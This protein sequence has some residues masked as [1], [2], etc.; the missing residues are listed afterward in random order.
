MNV[1]PREAVIPVHP[2][3]DRKTYSEKPTQKSQLQ[4]HEPSKPHLLA[5]MS[6]WVK[7]KSR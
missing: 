5:G 1:T 6:L 3:P 4:N 2:K 7:K